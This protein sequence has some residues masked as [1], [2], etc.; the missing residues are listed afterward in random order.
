MKQTDALLKTLLASDDSFG[1]EL[2]ELL[3]DKNVNLKTFSKHSGIPENTLYKI[4]SGHATNF[5]SNTI[6]AIFRTINKLEGP[7]KKFIA[8]IS[9]RTILDKLKKSEV[10]LK[11][12]KVI[13]KEYPATMLDEV[14][15]AAVRA[16]K[17]GAI[18]I[19]CG[20]I[21]AASIQGFIDIPITAFQYEYE[22]INKTIEQFITKHLN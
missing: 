8:I 15:G 21:A 14:I 5:G 10:H 22:A 12:T 18:G 9:N 17:E 6:R 1:K 19:V 11:G 2:K 20:P 3:K 7:Q 13:F 16:E 4:T